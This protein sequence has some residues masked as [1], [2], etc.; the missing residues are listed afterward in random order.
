MKKWFKLGFIALLLVVFTACSDPSD[1]YSR[2][3]EVEG[4]NCVFDGSEWSDD[5][6]NAIRYYD[7]AI[8]ATDNPDLKAKF[9]VEKAKIHTRMGEQE[10][11]DQ[12]S[13]ELVSVAEGGKEVCQSLHLMGFN[14]YEQGKYQESLEKY[15]QAMDACKGVREMSE[16]YDGARRRVCDLYHRKLDQ[17]EK[18]KEI[19]ADLYE[20]VVC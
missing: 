19:C 12:V 9:L 15:E 3:A 8:A 7:Q 2:V 16:G 6:E 13:H 20:M 18:A 5:C 4:R 10:E 14:L 1:E 11:L 17:C